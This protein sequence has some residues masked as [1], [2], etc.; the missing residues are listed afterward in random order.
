[1]RCKENERNYLYDTFDG[2]RVRKSEKRMGRE[3]FTTYPTAIM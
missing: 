2:R 1:M 3:M